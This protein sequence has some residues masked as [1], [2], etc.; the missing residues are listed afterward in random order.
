MAHTRILFFYILFVTFFSLMS[1]YFIA[2]Q[3]DGVDIVFSNIIYNAVTDTLETGVGWID[4]IAN[5]IF[6]P[7]L[8]IDILSTMLSLL[9]LSFVGLPSIINIII[10]TPLS[11]MIIL[12]Y[13]LPMIRGN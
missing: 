12:E 3:N 2:E 11:I 10:F 7:F 5:A 1:G 13:I 6:I 4:S 8:V 9:F